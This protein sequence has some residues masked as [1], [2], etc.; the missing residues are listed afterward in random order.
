[1]SEPSPPQ[2]GSQSFWKLIAFA[3]MFALVGVYILYNWYDDRLKAQISEKDGLIVQLSDRVKETEARRLAAE[4]GWN[5]SRAEIDA[6]KERFESEKQDLNDQIR[7]LEEIK[8]GLGQDMEGI[9]A[10]HAAVLADERQK[11]AQAVAEQERLAAAR[12]EVQA[13]LETERD[14]VQAL[15][16]DLG[17]VNVAIAEAATSHQQ[18]IAELERHLNERVSLARTTPEDAELLRTVQELG[19]LGTP[20]GRTAEAQAL[21]DELATAKAEFETLYK[22][23]E[24]VR[25][26]LAESQTALQKVRMDLELSHRDA[27]QA[28]QA[29]EALGRVAAIEADLNAEREARAA[30]QQ[31]Y[32]DAIAA[33]EAALAERDQR[34]TELQ[35]VLETARA[36]AGD[37]ARKTERLAAAESRIQELES[38]LETVRAEAEEARTTLNA[39]L[40]Q[41]RA[42]LAELQQAAETTAQDEN[43]ALTEATAR[44]AALEAELEQARA[45]DGDA[46]ALSAAQARIDALEAE[47]ETA[48]QSVQ[49]EAPSAD[50][51]E[52]AAELA[53][54]RALQTR[55]AQLNGTFTER[56]L[57]LSLAESELSFPTGRATLPTGELASLERIAEL[58]KA[59]PELTARIEGHT[60]SLGSAALNQ[61]LSLQRA[62]AVRQA[63]VERGVDGGR[64]SAEGLGPTRPIADNATAEGRGKNRRVEVYILDR[65]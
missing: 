6:L 29:R 51:S 16:A 28:G 42:R 52:A 1:M 62:E 58:L 20:E 26:R 8:V 11:T 2:S 9:K 60:D 41:A 5:A 35:T 43:Q 33:H 22:E 17:R 59:H 31:Q 39:A 3:L 10:A 61:S 53:R 56:G 44:I 37:E 30:L 57:L 13:R 12:D 19:L 63:L 32:D 4:E 50:Q 49:P 47:L 18:R 23:H 46:E 15:K 48:R 36:E 65:D 45:Q 38:S 64:L 27:A 24:A 14:K 7:M 25:T 40:E 34:L 21:A 54:L 55:F